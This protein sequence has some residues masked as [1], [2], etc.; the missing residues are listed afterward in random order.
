MIDRIVKTI[1]T[2]LLW[3]LL[4]FGCIRTLRSPSDINY[5]ENRSADKMPDFS[6][7]AYLD[8]SFQNGIENALADQIYGAQYLKK[9]YNE[10]TSSRVLQTVEREAVKHPD[11]FYCYRDVYLHDNRILWQPF[12]RD[13]FQIT[14]DQTIEAL[15]RSI[16]ENP[17]LPYY[18]YFVESD[19]VVDFKTGERIPVREEAC[20][21][22]HVEDA[23]KAWFAINTYD[24]FSEQFYR[25]DHHWNHK[26]A[27]RGYKEIHKLLNIDEPCLI[28]L[29]EVSLSR[30]MT[31]SKATHAG[32]AGMWE[33]PAVYEFDYPELGI[34]Y[35]H[36]REVIDNPGSGKFDY[37]Y[38]YGESAPL[39]TFDT[40]RPDRENILILGDSYTNAVLKLLASHY[41]R[42]YYVDMR[43]PGSQQFSI[44]RFSEENNVDLV[45]IIASQ[46]LFCGDFIVEG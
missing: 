26:G 27:Y 21:A 31:G 3:T 20:E 42:T 10:A 14:F 39:I 38:F 43:L 24:D 5:I 11:Y 32:F 25:T 46:V 34:E 9:W 6:F 33:N 28:P 45:L 8:S 35:G 2:G 18:F 4:I 16:A 40:N 7:T 23:H 15:N 13:A 30:Q 29:R 22:L 17:S 12:D 44:G 41:N 19:A 37:V 1:F 36:E